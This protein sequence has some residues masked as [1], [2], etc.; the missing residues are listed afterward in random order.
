MWSQMVTV[1]IGKEKFFARLCSISG[2]TVGVLIKW[3][4]II[5]KTGGHWSGVT[6]WLHILQKVLGG[7]DMKRSNV[8][9]TSFCVFFVSV[10]TETVGCL[11]H[12]NSYSTNL[13]YCS[14]VCRIIL[15]ADK[16]QMKEGW[17]N[18]EVWD[19]DT[20]K[21]KL[22]CGPPQEDK[23][24]EPCGEAPQ[25]VNVGNK[26]GPPNPKSFST[27]LRRWWGLISKLFKGFPFQNKSTENGDSNVPMAFKTTV[28]LKRINVIRSRPS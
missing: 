11:T 5:N 24:F 23:K 3:E 22:K 4:L 9:M 8:G 19:E 2:R 28:S 15:I 21:L 20:W 1:F 6:N 12:P 25:C 14:R 13:K 10:K 17:G 7:L 16:K 26:K 18:K 27:S